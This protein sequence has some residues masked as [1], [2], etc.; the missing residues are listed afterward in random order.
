MGGLAKRQEIVQSKSHPPKEAQTTSNLPKKFSL[1][2]IILIFFFLIMFF[3]TQ[4]FVF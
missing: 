4:Y 1:G 2:F 3:Q